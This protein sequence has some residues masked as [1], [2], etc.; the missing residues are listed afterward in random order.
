V[1]V[2]GFGTV[3]AEVVLAAL[4]P[5]QG[6]LA[7]NPQPLA[8]VLAVAVEALLMLLLLLVLAVLAVLAA[9]VAAV[10]AGR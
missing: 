1:A 6:L 4:L 2:T 3:A 10:A 8:R 5:L 9:V 7:L